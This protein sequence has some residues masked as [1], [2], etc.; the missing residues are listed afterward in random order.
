M[1][2]SPSPKVVEGTNLDDTWLKV[3]ELIRGTST[4]SVPNL[5]VHV[6]QPTR[7]VPE[8]LRNHEKEIQS[9]SEELQSTS[10]KRLPFTHGQRILTWAK[11]QKKTHLGGSLDQIKDFVVPMLLRNPKTKRAMLI[12][13][14]PSLDSDMTDDPIPALLLVQFRLSDDRLDTTA[15]FRAQEMYFF[16]LVNMFELMTLQ[17]KVCELM[18]LRSTDM[19]VRPG[20]ITTFAF[21]GYINP[22]DLEQLEKS[23]STTLA[24]ERFGISQMKQKDLQGL[25]KSA[26]IEG[27]SKYIRTLLDILS[28]DKQKLDRI[29]DIDYKGIE[30]WQ[31]FLETNKEDLRP[32]FRNL[33]EILRQVLFDLVS[34]DMELEREGKLDELKKRIVSADKAMNQLMSVL[35]QGKG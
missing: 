21:T 31:R 6:T 32:Q 11:G 8:P 24:I 22:V 10:P 30:V 16:W 9:W 35:E 29:R 33:P 34:L 17:E 26:L 19:L 25:L 4:G 2:N 1:T 23:E 12:V 20:S 5:I 27:N 7:L 18:R 13:S 3:V 28:N 14:D 15:Y